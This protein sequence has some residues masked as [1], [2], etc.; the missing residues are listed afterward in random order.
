LDGK[1]HVNINGDLLCVKDALFGMQFTG[2][3]GMLIARGAMHNPS[4]F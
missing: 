1:H 3:K 2:A 4:I